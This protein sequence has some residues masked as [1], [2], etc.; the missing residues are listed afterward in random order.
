MASEKVDLKNRQVWMEGDYSSKPVNLKNARVIEGLST[1]TETTIEFLSSNDAL[2]LQDIL[3]QTIT[4]GLKDEKDEDRYFTGTCIS[5]EYVGVYQ[6][7]SHFVAD[8]RPWLWFLTRTHENRIFQEKTVMDIIQE[9]LEEYGFWSDVEKK[10]SGTFKERVYCVQYKETDFDF[11]CRLME[12]EGIYY[13]F[14][15]DGKKLKMVLADSIS[16]HKPTPGTSEFEFHFKEAEYRRR[17]DHIFDWSEATNATTG[18][19]TLN[20]YDFEKPKADMKTAKSIAKGDHK[21]KSYEHYRYPGHSRIE[22]MGEDFTK[23]RMEAEAVRH[24]LSRGAGNVRALGVGQ[25]FKMKGHPRKKNNIEYL[26]TRAVHHLQIETDY[27][28]KE[29]KK[30]LFDSTI[31]VDE[32]NKDTYRIIFDVIPKTETFRA[33][34]TTPWPQLLGMQT[35]IVTGPSGEEIYTDKYGRIKVQFYWDRVGQKDE[36]TTCWV[37]CVMPWTGKNWG[38]ISI[39]RIGQEVAI[40]FEEGDPDRPICTGMLYNSD[41]MP[42]YGL[43]DNMTQTG[44]KT[45]SSK[46][47]GPA[48]YNELVF[49]DKKDSEFIRFHSEKDYFQ[50]VENNAEITI[51]VDKQDPGDLTQIIYHTKTENIQTGDHLF[52]VETGNQE[53]F[54][55]TDHTKTVE[56]TSTTTIKGDTTM[57]VE[58]GDYSQTISAGDVTREVSTGSESVTVSLGDYN[59]DTSVGS[60]VVTATTE[61]SLTVGSNSI[62]IDQSGITIS[63]IMVTVEGT[64]TVDVASPMTT[65]SG[66]GL[67]TLDGG[68]TMIN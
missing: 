22:G 4:L 55:K 38:M 41:T 44:I 43:P 65:V 13:Y 58:E 59:L 47:G 37:R 9:V 26:V 60:V 14:I 52:T 62:V 25:T 6:G 54:V 17:N 15:Q 33:P 18:K 28:D 24:K 46:E 29:T 3:G 16:A 32:D 19:V 48:N 2:D 31:E 27:E 49:E 23:V 56:G 39:P 7:L 53:I 45:R 68:T 51:G 63:G 40:Q 64:A 20:D 35:A 1:L 61:I 10:T 12:E 50:T 42:P 21:H 66:D 67:L 36:K 11:I 5:V 57:T 8:V 34:Q 30:P